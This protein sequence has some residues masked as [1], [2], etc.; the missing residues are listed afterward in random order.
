MSKSASTWPANVNRTDAIVLFDGVCNLCNW[1]VQFVIR[2]DP[3][4]RL[5]LAALQSPQG[6]ALLA[7][8][9]QML[10]DF[11]TMVF[12]ECGRAYFKST[13]V[14]RIARYLSWPWPCL[15]LALAIPQFGRDWCYDCVARNRY[16]VFGRRASCMVPTPEIQRRF[17][18]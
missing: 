4:A 3:D 18:T 5:R 6:Q 13:A 11:D 16:G 9:G 2:H 14:L 8:C 15:S 7:W 12:V 10:N 17:L 1:M